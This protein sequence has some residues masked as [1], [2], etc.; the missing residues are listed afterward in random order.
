MSEG[1]KKREA[2]LTFSDFLRL[3]MDIGLGGSLYRIGYD[4]LMDGIATSN[5]IS[6]I[7]GTVFLLLTA[8]MVSIAFLIPFLSLIIKNDT[9]AIKLKKS[10]KRNVPNF[11]TIESEM[12]SIPELS[13]NIDGIED[14]LPC[15][16]DVLKS[17]YAWLRDKENSAGLVV[18]TIMCLMLSVFLTVLNYHLY[19]NS[20]RAP[21]N[22]EFEALTVLGFHFYLRY[23]AG[24]KAILLF[25]SSL[26]L[27]SPVLFICG[28]VLFTLS[29]DLLRAILIIVGWLLGYAVGIFKRVLYLM[30][31]LSLYIDYFPIQSL[32]V[33]TVFIICASIIVFHNIDTILKED[34]ADVIVDDYEII[35]EENSSESVAN[36]EETTAPE[37]IPAYEAEIIAS[38]DETEGIDNNNVIAINDIL[39]KTGKYIY[40]SEGNRTIHYDPDCVN[41]C[42]EGKKQVHKKEFVAERDSYYATYS[43]CQMCGLDKVYLIKSKQMVH[44]K[45]DCINILPT[46]KIEEVERE[47]L[48]ENFKRCTFCFILH[49]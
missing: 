41:D 24:T 31:L 13:I 6:I 1:S 45:P 46:D 2:M 10:K 38:V 22:P 8:L 18:K 34:A 36:I 32:V 28:V 14:I 27:A 3:L 48:P 23:G 42:G 37:I 21:G 49:E 44:I 5:T 12:P 43:A 15:T 16:S 7:I 30:K 29:L 26:I 25:L 20:G 19:L 33:F 35:T 9:V 11:N 47:S 39:A 4:Q 17:F 40:I